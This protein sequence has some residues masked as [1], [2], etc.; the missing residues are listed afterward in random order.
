MGSRAN[1]SQLQTCYLLCFAGIA[2]VVKEEFQFHKIKGN[3]IDQRHLKNHDLLV[4]K[5]EADEI[6]KFQ[7]LR[8]VEDIFYAVNDTPFP[9]KRVSQ[10]KHHPQL[11]PKTIQKAVFQAINLKNTVFGKRANKKSINFTTF[12]KQ[13]IDHGSARKGVAN[14]LNQLLAS[15]FPKWKAN[16]PADIECWGFWVNHLLFAGIRIT[17]AHFRSRTYRKEERQGS[18]RPTIA[19]AMAILSQPHPHDEVLDPMCGTGT[20]LIERGYLAPY[21]GLQGYDWDQQAVRLARNNVDRTK[22]AKIDIHYGDARNLP[23]KEQ[24][25]NCILS[26]LPFGETYGSSKTN[27]ELYQNCLYQW[28]QLIS[29][30]GKAVLLTSNIKN[31]YQAQKQMCHYWYIKRKLR[32]KV[33]GIW[34]S[35]FVLSRR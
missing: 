22:L 4:W 16:D 2:E 29:S 24:H 13:D 7:S 10:L 1:S 8:T 27:F 32:F 18:L 20:I 12:V 21:I 33:L 3:F 19:A 34:A 28:S 17:P 9:L 5:G 11:N 35:C 31:F 26:N 25:F 6:S 23:I 14:Y 30:H 15:A